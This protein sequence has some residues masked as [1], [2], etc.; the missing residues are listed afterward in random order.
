MAGIGFELRKILQKDSLAAI[1]R[2]HFLGG[3]IV[4]GPFL[5]SVLCLTVLNYVGASSLSKTI[6]TNADFNIRQTFTSA[7]VYVFGGSLVATGPI[8][9]VLTRYLADK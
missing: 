6:G 8:Q 2:A 3:I 4:L 9:V 5:C 7:A 1:A